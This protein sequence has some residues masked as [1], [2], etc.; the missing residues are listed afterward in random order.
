MKTA[1]TIARYLLGLIF[2]TFGLNRFL[3][4]VPMPPPSGLQ[5]SS[6]ARFSYLGS[7]LYF[8]CCRS[9]PPC[10]FW[11]IG[12]FRWRLRSW[13]LSFSTFSVSTFS[14]RLPVC[15]WLWSSRSCGFL[16]LGVSGPLLRRSFNVK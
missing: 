10:F 14:W 15:R 11:Q 12:T 13:A 6:W 16:P 9:C 8:S 3:H 2:L 5:G 7:M 4:F 1:S